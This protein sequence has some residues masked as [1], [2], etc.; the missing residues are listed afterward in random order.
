MCHVLIIEDD[1]IAAIDIR[2]TLRSAGATSFSFAATE[3]EAMEAARSARPAVVTADV[4]LSAGSGTEAVR[5]IEAELG[6]LPVIFITA[7]PHQCEGE[8]AHPV[9]EKPFRT[10]ELANLFRTVWKA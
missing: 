3:R 1:A 5:A 8:S 10:D 6:P 9:I 4:M 7:T 2:D